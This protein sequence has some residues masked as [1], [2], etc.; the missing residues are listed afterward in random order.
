MVGDEKRLKVLAFADLH[1]DKRLLKSLK[2]RALDEEVDLVLICGDFTDWN[3]EAPKGLVQGFLDINKPVAIL[4][5]NHESTTTSAVLA[6]MYGV[7][8]LHGRSLSYKGVGI[9]GCGSCTQIG[10]HS[11]EEDEMMTRLDIAHS[12]IATLTRKLMVTHEHPADSTMEMGMFPGSN[13][14]RDAIHKFKP[15][16]LVCGHIHEA[17]GVEEIIGNTRV[18]NVSKRGRVIEL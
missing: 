4:S 2:K 9:F 1:A 15:D 8:H 17:E 10:P 7:T 12:K 14:I 18:V 3:E 13:S 5:G 16:V 6:D 11:I